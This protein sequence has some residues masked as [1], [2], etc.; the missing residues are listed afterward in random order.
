MLALRPGNSEGINAKYTAQYF[1]GLYE[2]AVK[3]CEE[4]IRSGYRSYLEHLFL[5]SSYA[6]SGLDAKEISERY[7]NL[8]EED[9]SDSMMKFWLAVTYIILNKDA[10]A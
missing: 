3:T 9:P 10:E 8:L 4:A 7:L 2:E 1:M 5:N 6:M